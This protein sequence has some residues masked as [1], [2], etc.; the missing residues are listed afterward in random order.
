MRA[1]S[2]P[3]TI[4]DNYHLKASSCT[5]DPESRIQSPYNTQ[6]PLETPQPIRH[7]AIGE[8][9]APER[10]EKKAE[11]PGACAHCGALV[12]RAGLS[13]KGKEVDA[14][15]ASR[16]TDFKH[17]KEDY[18]RLKRDMEY[19]K[20]ANNVLKAEKTQLSRN[21]TNLKSQFNSIAL[22]SPLNTKQS[23]FAQLRA[24]EQLAERTKA[25]ADQRINFLYKKLEG[26]IIRINTLESSMTELREVYAHDTTRLKAA[27]NALKIHLSQRR[28]QFA[29][30]NPLKTLA[31][32]E[33]P[34]RQHA[35]RKGSCFNM[36]PETDEP[37]IFIDDHDV[38]RRK[39]SY[40]RAGG[41]PERRRGGDSLCCTDLFSENMDMHLDINGLG[42][43]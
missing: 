29:I 35:A 12:A 42:I 10:P 16:K 9:I 5:Q 24:A 32:R 11:L 6:R 18:N 22:V 34:S 28:S 25:E 14:A 1:N 20:R 38:H 19:I 2:K 33:V 39:F 15:D 3:L 37:S 30:G 21:L 17:L 36:N 23:L 13:A 4:H 8:D 7:F 43:N 40:D 27:N 26:Y 41:D 31:G